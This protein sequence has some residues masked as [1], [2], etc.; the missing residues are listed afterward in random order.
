MSQTPMT[1]LTNISPAAARGRWLALLAA[2][3]GWLFDGVEIGLYPLISKPA[4]QEL[5]GGKAVL[6]ANPHLFE[7]NHVWVVAAFLIGAACGGALFGWLGDRFGRVRAMTWSVLSYSIFSGL[8]GLSQNVEQLVGLRFL[9]ALGMGGEWSLGVALVMEVWPSDKRWLLAGIIG[10]AANVGIALIAIAG[11]YINQL[12]AG[13]S[14]LGLS[15]ELVAKA[16]NNGGWR[17]LMMLGALPALLTFFIRLFVPE[18]EK[19]QHASKNSA[20][21]RLGEIFG[22]AHRRFVILGTIL[23]AVALLGTW[24]SVQNLP[25]IADDLS[26]KA[27]GARQHTQIWSA[28]GSV[29]GCLAASVLA[30][31]LTRRMSYFM[32]AVGSL[33]SCAF[34]FWFTPAYGSSFLALTFVV[35]AITASFYGWLPLYLPELFPTRL[36]A[37]AQGFAFNAGRVISASVIIMFGTK[38]DWFGGLATTCALISLVYVVGMVVIWFCPETKGKPLPE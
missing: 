15:D 23:A 7:T 8:C 31:F 5:V 4:I 30:L 37:T 33:V 3:L 19:W 2:F 34:L 27:A 24:G 10:A 11:L 36:R 9:S 32:M 14:A 35:G 20:P 1:P 12:G 21:V 38:P 17:L 28:L 13:L 29:T 25:A 22:T 18:S 26:N 6:D 16:T